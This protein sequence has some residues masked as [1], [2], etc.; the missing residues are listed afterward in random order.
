MPSSP[1]PRQGLSMPPRQRGQ[2]EIIR[3]RINH[4]SI[5]VGEKTGLLLVP[6][7]HSEKSTPSSSCRDEHGASSEKS[8]LTTKRCFWSA[9]FLCATKVAARF[10]I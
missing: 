1:K 4:S 3:D 8:D 10:R 2:P 6:S 7:N 5:A 9:E